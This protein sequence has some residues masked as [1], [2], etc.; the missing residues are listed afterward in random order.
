MT[1]PDRTGPGQETPDGRGTQRDIWVHRV[2]TV[3]DLTLLHGFPR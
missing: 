3:E 2:G 1:R